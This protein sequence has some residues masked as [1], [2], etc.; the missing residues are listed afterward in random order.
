MGGLALLA[1]HLPT[2]YPET[3]RPTTS[4]KMSAEQCDSDWIKVEGKR[5]FINIGASKVC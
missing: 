1:Q 3:I 4:E 2:V 5:R